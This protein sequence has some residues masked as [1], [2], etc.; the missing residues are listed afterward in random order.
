MELKAECV[1][2]TIGATPEGRSELLGFH[3]GIRESVQ[4]WW[5]LIIDIKARGLAIPLKWRWAM[6]PWGSGRRSTRSSPPPATSAAGSTRS[7][8]K[9]MVFTLVRAAPKTRRRL[10]GASHLPR[11]IEG[12]KFTD[13][14][15][16]SDLAKT[17]AA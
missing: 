4:S 10:N 17:S 3:V 1:L 9:L 5:E 14:V 7:R 15:A 13:G 12:V 8:I 2:V 6:A 16:N 11:V